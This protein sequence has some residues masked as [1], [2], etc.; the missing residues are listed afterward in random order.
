MI[1]GSCLG[2][3]ESTFHTTWVSDLCLMVSPGDRIEGMR[4]ALIIYLA[5]LIPLHVTLCSF[6][7]GHTETIKYNNTTIEKRRLC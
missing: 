3:R 1:Q 5:C 2:I 4:S 6:F 7:P